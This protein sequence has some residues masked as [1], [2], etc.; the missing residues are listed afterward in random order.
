MNFEENFGGVSGEG[1]KRE[2]VNRLP[3]VLRQRRM[4]KV[5]TSVTSCWQEKKKGGEIEKQP[6]QWAR[7]R[8]LFWV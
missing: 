7:W 5:F 2:T 1:E 8:F 4:S 3:E 6:Q